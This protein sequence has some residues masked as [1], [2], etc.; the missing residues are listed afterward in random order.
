MSY[1]LL[2]FDSVLQWRC[3][4]V[5]WYCYVHSTIARVVTRTPKSSH[6]TPVLKSLHWLKINESIKYK[7]LS[8]TYKVLTTHQS[9]SLTYK[10]LTTHQ[11]QYLHDLISVQPC[12]NTRSS[13]MVTLARP[14]THSSLKIT[15]RSFRYAAPSL[16]N[17]LP[18]D[19]CEPC[20]TQSPALSPITHGSSSSS[21]SPLASSL[22]RLVFHSE[23]KTWLFSKSFPP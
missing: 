10:V 8:L 1:R 3:H 7:L 19:L 11:S 4:G 5:D 14:P 12:H 2:I 18:T 23:L 22:T 9:Q 17:K 20:Q 15:N 13:S 6:I 16:W 21:L